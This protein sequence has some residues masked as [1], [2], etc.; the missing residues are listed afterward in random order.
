[1]K[2]KNSKQLLA[3]DTNVLFC[4]KKKVSYFFVL[5]YRKNSNISI[6]LFRIYYHP[7]LQ[8]IFRM[9]HKK[10]VQLEMLNSVKM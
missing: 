3:Y 5:V 2:K 7:I 10:F 6:C 9:N 4:D 8:M 1:M